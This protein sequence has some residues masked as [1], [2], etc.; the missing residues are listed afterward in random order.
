MQDTAGEAE[1]NVRLMLKLDYSD[2]A[3][4]YVIHYTYGNSR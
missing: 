3:V 1:T 2:I 4:Q